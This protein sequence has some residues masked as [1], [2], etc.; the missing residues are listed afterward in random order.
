MRRIVA[1]D[2]YAATDP[3]SPEEAVNEADGRT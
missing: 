3:K 2:N 1:A